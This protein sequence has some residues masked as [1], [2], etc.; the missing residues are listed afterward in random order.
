M[1]KSSLKQILLINIGAFILVL[2]LEI[3]SIIMIRE[4][5]DSAYEYYMWA[6]VYTVYIMGIIW[7]NH[8]IYIPYFLDKKR[9]ITYGILLLATIYF[10]A[11]IKT[12]HNGWTSVYKIF[13]FFI[14]STG[15]G[16]AAF[17]IRRNR[18]IQKENEEKEK[19]QKESELKYLKEQVNPHFLFNSLNSIYSLSRQSSPETPELVMQLSE[20]MRYQLESAKKDF[21][22]LKKELE[23]I[24]NYLLLEEK[25]LSKRCTIEF[26]IEG[27][28]SNYK[29]A[30]MLLIPFVEN[31][32]KHGAQSTNKQSKIDVSASIKNSTLYFCSVNSKPSKLSSPK[33][34][35]MGLENVKRRLNLLYPNSHVLKIENLEEVYRVNLSIDLKAQYKKGRINLPHG[36][37]SAVKAYTSLVLGRVIQLGYLTMEDLDKP[38]VSFLKDLNPK[39]FTKGTEKITL[40]KALTMRG[41]L[42]IDRDK[43]KEVEKDSVRLKGQ[44]MVQTL[45][46][47]SAPITSESQVYLYGNFNPLL[48]MM[49]I[50]AVV[51][52]TA[53]EF[54]KRELL[55]KLGITNY[56]WANHI[57]GI[58]EAGW[59]ASIMSRD[60]IKL[61]NLVLNKGK[62]KGEQLISSEY[63][64]KATKGIVKPT[65]DWMP[66]TYRYGYYWYQTNIVVGSKTYNATF[67]WGGGGQRVIVI[68]EL[69]L[70]IVISGHDREDKIMSQ[71]SEVLLPAFIK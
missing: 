24:E 52:G 63:L 4:K 14:Y 46:E 11:Y 71:I 49:V 37:A 69:D 32:I 40:H 53:E 39:K 31:A 21:V 33:R 43:W 57:S 20:L 25:R 19:L 67:A 50:D 60:M 38:L 36:Q 27:E 12:S 30:P 15:T 65:Q 13:F 22:L 61:G 18:I 6:V 41:G 51:P 45:L 48:V 5:F 54:I 56:K 9:Y 35:G 2:I 16:M 10:A 66:K 70:T 58:P 68:E 17:Y 26:L 44:G 34:K 23:F 1:F 42:G 7:M 28:L 59:K 62:F 55:D 8:F 64:T 29:I 3:M 47:F